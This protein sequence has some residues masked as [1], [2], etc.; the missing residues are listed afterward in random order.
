MILYMENPKESTKAIRTSKFS[1][2]ARYKIDIQK[3]QLYF[4]Q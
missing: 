3:N 2:I 1:K 4:M